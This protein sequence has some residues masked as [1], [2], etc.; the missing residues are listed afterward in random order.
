MER[1]TVAGVAG[2]AVA[3]GAIVRG[4][5]A[6]EVEA[7]TE[8]TLSRPNLPGPSAETRTKLTAGW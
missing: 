4:D 8:V 5:P 1:E 7:G 2:Q 6:P 3:A